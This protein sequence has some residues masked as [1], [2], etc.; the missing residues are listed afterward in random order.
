MANIRHNNIQWAHRQEHWKQQD[1][2]R[3]YQSTYDLI[4][5][6]LAM[7]DRI[8]TRILWKN[9]Q[10]ITLL[11]HDDLSAWSLLFPSDQLRQEQ[12]IALGSGQVDCYENIKPF[13]NTC[14]QKGWLKIRISPCGYSDDPGICYLLMV[15]DYSSY[16]KFEEELTFLKFHDEL[17][18]LHNRTYFDH[19]KKD[20]DQACNLPLSYIICDINGLKLINETLSYTAGDKVLLSTAKI[21]S[22]CCRESDVL[23]RIGGDEF[24]LLLPK[25]DKHSAVI[26]LN[27]ITAAAKARSPLSAPATGF[28]SLSLG[29]ATKEVSA[30]PLDQII[31]DAEN[32]LVRQ[33]LFEQKSLHSSLLASIKATMHEKSFETKEHGERMAQMARALGRSLGLSDSQLQDLELLANMH[34]IG[35]IIIDDRILNKPG[36]LSDEEWLEMKKHPEIGYRIAQASPD[37]KHIADSIL[38]HHERWDGNGYPQGLSGEHIP[39]FSRILAIVDAFDAMTNDRAYRR[40]MTHSDALSEIKRNAGS[41]FDPVIAE[42]FIQL[43]KHETSYAH[44]RH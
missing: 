36:K 43:L 44:F 4:P 15:E 1:Q 18:Q 5:V 38:F 17:T 28:L 31:K 26:L 11:G 3:F 21:L 30:E 8:S 42:E 32:H 39:V 40:A 23:A 9:K 19:A 7:I 24:A 41:Q 33:K 16:K 13:T 12:M 29:Y 34:D 20:L 22:D 37:I 2:I 27:R 25:T 10:F 6:G 14:G 35:K